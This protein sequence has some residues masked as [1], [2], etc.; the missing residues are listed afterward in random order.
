[1]DTF[2]LF[3]LTLPIFL[4][5]I[6]A[7]GYDIIL[8]G[9][10]TTIMTEFALVTPPIG[11]NV[12]ILCGVARDIPMYTVFRGIVPFLLAMAVGLALVMAFPQIALFLPNTMR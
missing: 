8:F 1:M 12:F 3:F 4:P 2:S 5:I 10:V 7:I 9:V 11:L 6:R